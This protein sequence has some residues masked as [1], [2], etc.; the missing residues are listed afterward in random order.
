MDASAITRSDATKE[1]EVV[2][3]PPAAKDFSLIRIPITAD[4][5]IFPAFIA[6][7]LQG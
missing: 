7:H 2:T 5:D 3:C 4:V 6:P 1:P